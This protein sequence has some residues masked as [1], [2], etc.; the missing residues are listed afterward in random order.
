[1][2]HWDEEMFETVTPPAGQCKVCAHALEPVTIKGTPHERYAFGNCDKYELKPTGV[3]W[4]E[5]KCPEY[6]ERDVDTNQRNR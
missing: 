1:M 3:L 4:D 6:K 2:A 5:A